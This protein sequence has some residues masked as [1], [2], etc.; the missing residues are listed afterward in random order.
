MRVK[1]VPPQSVTEPHH[2]AFLHGAV[3]LEAAQVF[4]DS[5]PASGLEFGLH[6]W[7]IAVSMRG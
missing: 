6:A 1:L 2:V 7:L 5:K 3:A 4:G